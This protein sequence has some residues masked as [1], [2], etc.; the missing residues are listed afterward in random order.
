MAIGTL[1]RW[2]EGRAATRVVDLVGYGGLCG[3][4]GGAELR[5]ET[6]WL[7]WFAVG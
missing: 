6:V 3:E 1:V 5:S 7:E 2:V 4:D